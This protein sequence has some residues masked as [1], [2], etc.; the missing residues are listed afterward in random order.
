M[1]IKFT[2]RFWKLHDKFKDLPIF[3]LNLSTIPNL[4]ECPAIMQLR[5]NC[6]NQ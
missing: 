1:L 5:D 6:R 3:H 2:P 4:N